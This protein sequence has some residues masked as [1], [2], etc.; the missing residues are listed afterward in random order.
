MPS[1]YIDLKNSPMLGVHAGRAS[2]KLVLRPG[3]AASNAPVYC[4]YLH[5]S[6]STRLGPIFV[7]LV[8]IKSI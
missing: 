4:I 3:D 2:M 5:P 8:E 1:A 6:L 7:L